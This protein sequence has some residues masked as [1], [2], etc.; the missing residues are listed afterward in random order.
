MRT[1]I[2][3]SSFPEEL[4]TAHANEMLHASTSDHPYCRSGTRVVLQGSSEFVNANFI[5]PN[6]ICGGEPDSPLHFW[7]MVVQCKCRA[8][9]KLTQDMGSE[10][11]PL[12]T[13]ESQVYGRITVTNRSSSRSSNEVTKRILGVE[14]QGYQPF[15]L[16]HF[17]YSWSDFGV[18]KRIEPIQ[19]MFAALYRLPSDCS[20]FVHCRAGIGRAGTFIT[21]DHVLRCILGGNLSVVNISETVAR[22][23]EQRRGLV[24][25]HDQ[26]WFCF[27]AVIKELE[28]LMFSAQPKNQEF[29]ASAR[30]LEV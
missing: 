14:C 20:Y 21:I 30:K 27:K 13:G 6:A 4:V 7:E 5:T 29:H 9:V 8:V 1:L 25:T 2:D 11:F 22:L 3:R 28:L 26:Y 23:R 10:Y 19:E 18:P 17:Q 15:T 12:R 16:E 24:E